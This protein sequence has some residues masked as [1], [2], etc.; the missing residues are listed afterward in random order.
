MDEQGG[1]GIG[2]N[3]YALVSY[4]SGPLAE[5][6][7]RLRERLAPGCVA[8]AHVTV[9]PPRPITGSA[10]AAWKELTQHLQDFPA[11]AVELGDVQVFRESQVIYVSVRAGK[12]EL[13]N[14][15]SRLNRGL[16]NFDE[17][18]PYHPHITL[19][20]E[21]ISETVPPALEL[22]RRLWDECAHPRAFVVNRL[23]FVQNTLDN[24]WM[25][26]SAADLTRQT[27]SR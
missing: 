10:E 7:D 25:D 15:H 27:I 6:L 17:P 9:L 14:L 18:F 8:K 21:L 20:Q 2:I 1:R 22:A 13:D 5:F 26:L 12:A 3:S 4:L 23:T 19:A 16:V 24:Q 11:I